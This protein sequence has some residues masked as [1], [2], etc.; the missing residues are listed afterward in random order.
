M[1][2]GRMLA[3]A[4]GQY[5]AELEKP[6]PTAARLADAEPCRAGG[7]MKRDQGGAAGAGTSGR[8]WVLSRVHERGDQV[9]AR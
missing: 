8:P 6:P 4:V 2:V 3:E 9:C 1:T 7:V 5:V